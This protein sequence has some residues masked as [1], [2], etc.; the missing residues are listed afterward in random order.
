VVLGSCDSEQPVSHAPEIDRLTI[1]YSALRISLPIFVA[2]ERRIFREHG[3]EV[4]LRRY[5][6]AQPLVEEVL[7]G[8]VLAGGFAALPI[9]FTAAARGDSEVRLGLA[10]IEDAEHP[11]SYLLRRSGDASLDSVAAL[12]GRRVG[13]LPTIAYQRWLEAIVR[14]AGVDPSEVV[15]VPVAPPHQ[16]ATLEGGGVD[17]LVTNDPVATATIAAGV[18]ERVGPPAPVPSATHEPLV[19]GSFLV[20]PRLLAE[21]P[22]LVRRLLAALDDAAA[23][24]ESDQEG[25]R[26]AMTSYVRASERPFVSRYPDARYLQSAHFGDAE[27]A[28]AVRSMVELGVLDRGRDVTGW[29]LHAEA[30][31]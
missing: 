3:L 2:Q 21:R 11:V 28:G 29:T 8:R 22:D 18:G 6:T 27:L 12:R 23:L 1:G 7:D 31:R 25:A 17:A 24:I 10:M 4:E 15:I 19:F 5:E 9:I 30:P 20:H 26:R 14:E 13:I 16:T